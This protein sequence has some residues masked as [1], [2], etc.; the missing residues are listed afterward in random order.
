MVRPG[1]THVC[2]HLRPNLVL[3]PGEPV[4]DVKRLFVQWRTRSSVQ[5][6]FDADAAALEQAIRGAKLPDEAARKRLLDRLESDEEDEELPQMVQSS[7]LIAALIRLLLKR[8][9]FTQEEL[10]EELKKR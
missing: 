10:L 8:D 1:T 3:C 5:H 7:H 9:V 2:C 4:T 6:R